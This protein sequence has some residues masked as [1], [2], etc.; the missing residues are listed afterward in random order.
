MTH[1]V[2][3]IDDDPTVLTNLEGLLKR[4]GFAV[5]TGA[6]AGDM[7]RLLEGPRTD[8]LILDIILPDLPEKTTGVDL[9]PDLQRT[10]PM[11]PVIILTSEN[12]VDLA[13]KAMKSGARDYLV[14][15]V[16]PEL[17]EITVHQAIEHR[18]QVE[19]LEALR[20]GLGALD[21]L[22]GMIG[23]HPSMQLLYAQIENVAPSNGKRDGQR[24]GGAG[25]ARQEPAGARPVCGHQLRGDSARAA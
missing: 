25:L 21:S 15:P 14:K 9:L 16:D 6:S 7:W 3:V 13:V 4:S 12:K 8:V 2:L 18:D 11:L 1:T 24:V 10:H 22:G 17:L 19:E 23:T 20:R 5:T